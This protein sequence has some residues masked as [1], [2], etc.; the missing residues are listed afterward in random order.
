MTGT[1]R[2]ALTLDALL[3]ITDPAERA[4]AQQAVDAL[5]EQAPAGLV[6]QATAASRDVRHRMIDAGARL[7]DAADVP[8]W[9]RL[10]AIEALVVFVAGTGTT[11]RHN[12]SPR[13]P[14]PIAAAA[15]K[16]GLIICGAACRHLLRLHGDDDRRCDLCGHVGD[17]IY[18]ATVAVGS[19][20]YTAGLCPDCERARAGS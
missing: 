2:A 1:G 20:V 16:P 8:D 13:N 19:L 17:V 11:C 18:P 6:D 7:A 10:Q 4:A 14:Q 15:W 3:T 9:L 5:L 12:P